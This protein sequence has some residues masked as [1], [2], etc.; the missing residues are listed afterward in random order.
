MRKIIYLLV[1]MGAVF[2]GC[3]PMEDINNTIDL[4]E[5]AVVGTDEITLTPDD[6]A[7]M[8]PSTGDDFYETY[9]SFSDMDDAKLTIPDFLSDKYPNWGQG[10]SVLVHFDLYDGNPEDVSAYTN[11]DMYE[12]SGNDYPTAGGGAFLPSE[13]FDNTIPNFLDA[14]VASPTEGDITMV[15]YKQFTQEPE[16]G[17]A[18]ILEYD[19]TS[20]LES[21]T[22][23]EVSGGNIV[24]TSSTGFIVGNGFFGGAAVANEEWLVSP[25]IDLT[26]QSNL[27]LQITQEIDFLSVLDQIDIMVSTDYS[28]DVTTATWNALVFDKTAYGNMTTSEDFDFSAYDGQTITIAFKYVSSDTDAARWRIQSLT[29]KTVGLSGP[30]STKSVYYKY[31]GSSWNLVDGVYV[32]TAEDYDSMGAPGQY[33]NFSSSV[34]PQNY[35]PVFLGLNYPYT[36]EEDTMF[37]IYKYYTSGVGTELKG[38]LYTFIN[39]EWIHN[40]TSLQFG[41]E[42]GVWVP[43]NTIRYTLTNADYEYIGNTLSSDPEYSDLVGTLLTYHDYDYNW[44]DAQIIYS[45]GVFLDYFDPSAEEGQKYAITYLKYDNGLAEL[46]ASLIKQDGEWIAN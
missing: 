45:L 43:D 24:W 32:L 3:D 27:A 29:L 22:P 18:P 5:S 16:V 9:L 17:L 41:F 28:G 44:S 20:S 34:L 7:E 37:V 33:D 19:F 25:S 8:D 11:A 10:S 13:D 35:I 31:D 38:N 12:L 14:N 40:M 6:Y 36:Q 23:A 1:V 26:T 30:T 42:D 39:G 4:Q 2:Y 46:S 21:W 15:E